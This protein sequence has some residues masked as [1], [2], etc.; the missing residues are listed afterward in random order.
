MTPALLDLPA[1]LFGAIDATL[2]FAPAALRIALYAC[3]CAWSGMVLYRRT[4]DQARLRELVGA[5]TQS[6]RALAAHEGDFA[7]LR[8]LIRRNFTLTLRRLWLTTR[9]ALV[10]SLPL[11]F[12]LPWLSDRFSCNSP[13]ALQTIH[14]CVTPATAATRLHWTTPTATAEPGC[15]RVTWPVAGVAAGVADA[16]GRTIYTSAAP[17]STSVEKFAW[18]NYLIGNP[19]GY[20]PDAGPIDRIDLDLDMQQ[21]VPFGPL[22]LRKWETYFFLVLFAISLALKFRWKIV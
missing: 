18:F 8:A 10:A 11:L 7:E 4:S 17:R 14:A 6:Q 5:V 15:W 16:S 20:L 1:P 19:D 22:W 2:A 3:A 12:A 13:A 21:I 9:P